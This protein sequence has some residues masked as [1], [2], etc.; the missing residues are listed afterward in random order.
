LENSKNGYNKQA[1]QWVFQ[2]LQS[3]S[4]ISN[5]L[6]AGYAKE[7]L[8]E[9]NTHTK[10][11]PQ[12]IS[13]EYIGSN[14]LNL[15]PST[16]ILLDRIQKRTIIEP[17]LRD[18]KR[19]YLQDQSEGVY[20]PPMAKTTIHS[21]DSFDLKQKVNEF[22]SSDKKVLLILGDSGAGKSTFNRT[23]GAELWNHYKP[24]DRIPLFIYLPSI[25]KPDDDLVA[26]HLRK[27]G[28][29]EDEIIQLKMNREFILICDAYDETQLQPNLYRKNQLNEYGGWKAR[30]I[31]SC[32]IEY[33]GSGKNYVNQF[34]PGTR[35]NAGIS[36]QFQE[37]IVA[38]FNKQQISEYIQQ[39]ISICKPTWGLEKYEEAFQKIPNLL[40]LI[41]NP[42]LLRL[43]IETLQEL[44]DSNT[45]LK[46]T[47]ITR[48]MLY[49]QF[50]TY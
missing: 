35:N 39:Y 36:D 27:F 38:P 15:T 11:P 46:S 34:Q 50:V 40:D 7:C 3:L 30:M 1:D 22:L 48:A 20:I 33:I 2:I 5:P 18:I 32:R 28:I 13:L 26:K 14:S 41:T 24:G 21:K 31:I 42:S 49:D 23:L 45:S 29:T 43:S 19:I 37:Y 9:L 17:R 8:L 16:S 10:T 25:D 12:E 4:E 47:P 6:V 44:V